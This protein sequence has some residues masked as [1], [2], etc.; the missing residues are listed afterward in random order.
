VL[1]T[2]LASFERTPLV[3]TT[4]SIITHEASQCRVRRHVP[5][6]AQVDQATD[7]DTSLVIVALHAEA[8]ACCL[9]L[10]VFL[11]ALSSISSTPEQKLGGNKSKAVGISG[12]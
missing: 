6:I 11:V 2:A 4:A 3:T 5:F 7:D 8:L 9:L 1:T 10:L 12:S